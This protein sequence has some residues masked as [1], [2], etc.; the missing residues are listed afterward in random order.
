M[1]YQQMPFL[2]VKPSFLLPF[3][4]LF[5]FFRLIMFKAPQALLLVGKMPSH[6]ISPL[7][8]GGKEGAT[9]RRGGGRA[10][11]ISPA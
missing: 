9:C 3:L 10:G 1:V 6:K 7:E 11:K 8:A 2:C 5:L 4:T